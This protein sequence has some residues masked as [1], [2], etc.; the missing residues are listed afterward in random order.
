L[1]GLTPLGAGL[2]AL[3]R[4][5]VARRA[6]RRPGRGDRQPAPTLANRRVLVVGG[7]NSGCDIAVESAQH[8][9]ATFHSLRRGYHYVPKYLFGVPADQAGDRL[10]RW[11]LPLW[12]RRRIVSLLLRLAV[13]RPEQ[14]GLPAADHKLFETH[15]IVNSLLL[16][17][18]RHGDI[19][20]KPD[21]A[22]LDGHEVAFR[23]GSREAIDVIVYATGY[24]LDFPFIDRRWLNWRDGR[25]VLWRHA[26]HPVFDN[27]FVA[28]MI[29]PD[30]GLFGLVHWQTTAMAWYL[31]GL[32]R[33]E[34]SALRLRQLKAA[35]AAP[36]YHEDLGAGIRYLETPRH[37]IEV[38]H[39]SYAREMRR[40]AEALQS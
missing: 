30:S 9:A 35:A 23:D 34:P 11:R 16:Y 1:P 29:Q 12:L 8:A 18:V 33:G 40:L 28:G 31:V 14:Y 24:E 2:A 27:L 39:W 13:G 19:R 37:L 7:G 32:Q 15:P 17:Y 25:P 6:P 21:I 26:F 10:L 38:E 5:H 22:Q 4:D 36:D 3:D 20:P